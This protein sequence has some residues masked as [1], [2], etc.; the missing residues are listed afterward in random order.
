MNPHLD[1]AYR[2]LYKKRYPLIFLM[3][4]FLSYGLF[5]PFIGYYL[6]DWYL[7]WFK[8]VFGAV[9]YIQYFS[10]DRPLMGYFYIAANF[11]LGGSETPLVWQ[12]FG[13]FT[14]W[15]SVVALWQ[16]LNTIWPNAK[17]QNIYVALLAAV[18]PGFTQQWIAAIYSFFFTCLA[19]F[20][21]SISLML[22]GLRSPQRF[23][24]YY[25]G[26]LLMM[27]Y[28]IPASEFFFGLEFIRLLV[29]WFEFRKDRA[30]FWN[31]FKKLGIYGS[32]YV[33]ILVLFW[34][35]RALFFTSTNHGLDLSAWL[36]GGIGKVITQN[37]TYL[38]QAIITATVHTWVNLVNLS[39]YPSNGIQ[40]LAIL[41]FV[42]VVFLAVFIW[43][44]KIKP[45]AREKEQLIVWR[46]QAPILGLISMVLAI[47]P[48]WAANL[49]IDNKFPYDRFLLAFLFGSCLIMVWLFEGLNFYAARIVFLVVALLVSVGMGYQIANANRYRTT[50]E[51]QTQF[52]WQLDWRI[53]GLA[54]NTMLVSYQLPDA[55]PYS[56]SANQLAETELWSGYALSAFLNWTYA[57]SVINRRIDYYFFIINS[58]QRPEIPVL[59][60]S[61]PVTSNFRTYSFVG[62]TS[63]AVYIYYP[64]YGCLRVLDSEITPPRTVINILA[65]QQK[66]DT[67]NAANLTNLNLIITGNGG[68]PPLQIIGNE[69]QKN[70]CFFFEKA[71]FAHQEQDY[72]TVVSLYSEALNK[73]LKPLQPTEIY[74]FVDAF[75]RTGDWATAEKMTT[76]LMPVKSP[77]LTIG[78]CHLWKTLASDFPGEPSAA[79]II[80]QLN[81][82]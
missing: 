54:P 60:P 74:P 24:L 28:V 11:I 56:V 5:L 43:L 44:R 9:D 38:Y 6:D 48:F 40:A 39:N 41:G 29:L 36:T 61:Q 50:W 19:G 2:F 12:I 59:S 1:A 77:A 26:S 17:R 4:C 82:D 16:M 20:F 65:Q 64:I 63:Q 21:F 3:I 10:L 53:P 7:I 68:H 35:W 58:G 52:F 32:P 22:K 25:L 73:H 30:K 75:A 72:A 15:L 70:W 57:D 51:L 18:F 49:P 71:E 81:C 14:R 55:D 33:V 27:A 13:V 79:H 76:E 45:G 66:V 31:S 34:V 8:H 62:N 47:L 42:I 78:L 80:D 37:L 67:I 23:W 46:K 69:P